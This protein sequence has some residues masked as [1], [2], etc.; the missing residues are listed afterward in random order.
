MTLKEFICWKRNVRPNII[1]AVYMSGN[2]PTTYFDYKHRLLAIGHLWEQRQQQ[3]KQSQSLSSSPT[4]DPTPP[5]PVSSDSTVINAPIS[6][7]I[8]TPIL[9]SHPQILP[10]PDQS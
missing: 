10:R 2:L 3:R 7:P 5:T 9:P 1:D 8:S 4:I 6:T